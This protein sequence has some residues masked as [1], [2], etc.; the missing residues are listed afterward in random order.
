P[1]D[2]PTD[3]PTD[4]TDPPTEPTD[5]PTE[6]TDPPTDPTDPPTEPTDPPT[7]PTDPP[8]EPTDPP[9]DPTD[10]P[11]EPTDPPTEPTDP[12]TELPTEPTPP[13]VQSGEV[14]DHAVLPD[15]GV[16][17]DETLDATGSAEEAQAEAQTE[18]LAS[19]GTA[20]AELAWVVVGTTAV[21]GVLLAA[22]TS[23]RVKAQVATSETTG[24]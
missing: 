13:V 19:T 15:G 21:G 17:A 16:A 11:T 14:E 12:P 8:T 10:P 6:P 23:R 7:D 1:A 2:E 22:S 3:P 9:T 20:A 4:P 18:V 24:Q 5:P